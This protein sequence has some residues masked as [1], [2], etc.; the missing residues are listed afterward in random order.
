MRNKLEVCEDFSYMKQ[1]SLQRR[2]VLWQREGEHAMAFTLEACKR[3]NS[4]SSSS[5]T[6]KKQDLSLQMKVV[7]TQSKTVMQGAQRHLTL[8]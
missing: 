4:L 5:F 7:L 3:D 6:L 1:I 8:Q 2:N